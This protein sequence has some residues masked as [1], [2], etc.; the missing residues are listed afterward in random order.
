MTKVVTPIAIQGG[1]SWCFSQ[2]QEVSSSRVRDAIVTLSSVRL[3][4]LLIKVR[5]GKSLDP[6]ACET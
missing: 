4:H 5:H 6:A 3:A 2:N 1:E